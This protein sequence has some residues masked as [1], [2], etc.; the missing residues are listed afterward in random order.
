MGDN[1]TKDEHLGLSAISDSFFH[2]LR[3]HFLWLIL[4]LVFTTVGAV[5][6]AYLKAP[7]YKSRL[8]FALDMGGASGELSGAAGIA[9]QLGFNIGGGADMFAEDNII[10]IILSR[11]VIE[12]VLMSEYPFGKKNQKLIEYFLNESGIRKDVPSKS[13]FKTV[14]FPN[15]ISKNQLNYVQD[16]VLMETY[17]MFNKEMIAV[18][19][20][21][22]KLNIYQ[23]SV[24]TWNEEFSKVFTDRLMASTDTF[25]KEVCTKKS[26]NT[27]EVLEQ[28]AE[29]MKENLHG[30][31]V[32]KSKNIDANLN[33]AFTESLVPVEKKQ[34]DV[35][36]YGAAYAELFKNLEIARYQYL[37]DVPLVQIIDE[38][39]YPMEMVKIKLPIAAI[40]GAVIGLFLFSGI[41]GVW[42]LLKGS[43]KN[44]PAT[45]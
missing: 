32:E 1:L 22:K 19:R 4:T 25:Y 30:S 26:A 11:R 40:I 18:S 37:K 14:H 36:V 43:G 17:L 9:S 23:V 45:A 29:F 39:N 24:K 5:L 38:A 3:K 13:A 27:L 31:M 44:K 2:I 35:E 16:S 15:D 7:E 6:Y 42:V 41:A 20:P 8:T 21:D 10:E 28:R 34:F 33:P 12:D